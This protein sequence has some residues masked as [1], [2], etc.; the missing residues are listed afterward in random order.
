MTQP[1]SLSLRLLLLIF[2][3]IGVSFATSFMLL[4]LPEHTTMSILAKLNYTAKF[5][6][7]YW[8]HEAVD[9]ARDAYVFNHLL[10]MKLPKMHEHLSKNQYVA[11]LPLGQLL[12]LAS[13]PIM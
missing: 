13:L 9:F 7:G 10:Q 6:P 3:C 1:L 11:A 4:F 2:R 12:C 5:I 8:K